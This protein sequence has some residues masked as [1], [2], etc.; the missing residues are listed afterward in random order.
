MK[1]FKRGFLRVLG[2][3]IA[4]G[5]GKDSVGPPADYTLS[6]SSATLVIAQG[7]SGTVNV[8][9]G[10]TNFSDA[11]SLSLTDVPP[12]ISGSFNPPSS[13]NASSI[14]TLNVGEAVEPGAYHLTVKGNATAG[15][16][17]TPLTVS[18]S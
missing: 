11:I 3:P 9:I 7:A 12:G 17:S 2:L 1:T 14:L 6:L 5:C 15:D 4:V 10:R 8:G 18:V 13:T 16:R